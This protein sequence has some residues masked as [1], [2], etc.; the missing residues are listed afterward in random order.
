MKDSFWKKWETG[1]IG[2]KQ[3]SVFVLRK[4]WYYSAV[5]KSC[6]CK[7]TKLYFYRCKYIFEEQT[8]DESQC[9]HFHPLMYQDL[10]LYSQS[11]S[12]QSVTHSCILSND[13][14]YILLHSL[15]VCLVKSVL[16]SVCFQ[17][18]TESII[19]RTLVEKLTS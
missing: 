6:R 11:S 10:Y 12:L 14:F 19:K 5:L 18:G 8:Q 4:N 13:V 16:Q 2:I 3:Y 7:Q 9:I 17:T 1:W 15:L